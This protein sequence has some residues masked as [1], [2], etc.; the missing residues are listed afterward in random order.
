MEKKHNISLPKGKKATNIKTNIV[1]DKIEVSYDLEDIYVPKFGDI[2]KV[3]DIPKFKR[4]YMICIYPKREDPWNEGYIEGFFNIANLDLNGRLS[5]ECGNKNDGELRIIQASESEKQELF[6]RLAEVGKRWNPDTKQIED[7]RWRPKEGEQ[8]CFVNSLGEVQETTY[9][10]TY[11][12]DKK[13]V[14]ICNCF[15]TKEAAKPY[16]DQI[17]EIFKNSKS[18]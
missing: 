6:D 1:D 8:Y 11:Y 2:V 16:V 5:F 13:R 7:I 15:R 10:D 12:F 17:K 9:S 3:I 14:E 18:E 4:N